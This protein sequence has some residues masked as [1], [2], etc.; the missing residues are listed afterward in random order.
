VDSCETRGGKTTVEARMTAALTYLL[1]PAALL[2]VFSSRLVQA[3]DVWSYDG[4]AGHEEWSKLGY[5]QCSGQRQSPINVVT[6]RVVRKHFKPIEFRNFDQIPTEM[7]LTNN[8]HTAKATLEWE[9]VPHIRSGGLPGDYKVI[10][11]HFHWGKYDYKGSEHTVDGESYPLEMHIVCQNTK[12]EAIE[13]AL[14]HPDGL[15]VLGIMFEVSEANNRAMKRLE[16]ALREIVKGGASLS[17]DEPPRLME[18]MPWNTNDFYR[19]DG[20]LTT[21]NCNEVVT[22]TIFLE[23][24][25]ITEKQLALFR[26]LKGD[27]VPIGRNYRPPQN[28]YGRS[29]FLSKPEEEDVVEVL[30]AGRTSELKLE[31]AAAGTGGA[32]LT[33]LLALVAA[34]LA[35]H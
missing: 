25:K 34:G 8:Y 21:P 13:E 16:P 17:V 9:R 18:L 6:N 5:H 23:T 31:G 12:Y 4:E 15:A 24:V 29:V 14:Q 19:Y 7:N 28:R 33:A 27:P 2:T 30:F 3:G 22:W 35:A 11:F 26:Q 32:G 10:N 1:V 20:S